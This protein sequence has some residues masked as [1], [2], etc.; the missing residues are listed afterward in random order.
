MVLL[1][2][3][4]LLAFCDNLW[5]S[6][7]DHCTLHSFVQTKCLTKFGIKTWDLK[8][9]K[10]CGFRVA[11][12]CKRCIVMYMH[13]LCV[14]DAQNPATSLILS[15]FYSC[16]VWGVVMQCNTLRL[17]MLNKQTVT[18]VTVAPLRGLACST[19]CLE[20]SHL[21]SMIPG[22]RAVLP[23]QTHWPLAVSPLAMSIMV[24]FT[25][26]LNTLIREIRTQIATVV[27]RSRTEQ[28]FPLFRVG[29]FKAVILSC[30]TSKS[31]HVR[32]SNRGFL[33]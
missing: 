26:E 4:R 27:C 11:P 3:W 19:H 23:W 17:V 22:T 32:P 12:P 24:C 6:L 29:A 20:L 25:L 5:L 1:S 30:Q 31:M 14:S 10:K 21:K 7:L 9:W 8:T 2:H 33:S 16:Q 15:R 13:V 18:T 28:Q